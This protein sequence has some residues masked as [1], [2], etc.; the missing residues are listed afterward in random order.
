MKIKWLGHACFKFTCS[1]GT[2]VITDPFDP[3]VGYG[4][5]NE[6]ADIL[7]VSHEHHDHCNIRAVKGVKLTV[8][9][10]GDFEFGG[11]NITAIPSFHDDCRGAKRGGN[12]LV[13]IQADG[14]TVVHLGDLGHM[15]DDAQLEFIKNADALLIPIGGFYTIDTPSALEILRLATPRH[16]VAMH[17]SNFFCRF[18]ISS[19]EEFA[20]ATGAKMIKGEADVASL[21]PYAVFDFQDE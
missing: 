20:N 3:S 16:A 9:R 13:K 4:E 10:A 11:V 1:N 2:T 7:T 18:P 14:Q 12:L 19:E 6:S 17:F 5:L 8:D 15:P 21:P